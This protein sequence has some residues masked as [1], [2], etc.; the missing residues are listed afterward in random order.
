M[1]SAKKDAHGVPQDRLEMQ[2]C[3]G[4]GG[5]VLGCPKLMPSSSLGT[6]VGNSASLSSAV[7]LTVGMFAKRCGCKVS[8]LGQTGA[9][10]SRNESGACL[11]D[12]FSAC[13]SSLEEDCFFICICFIIYI[14]KFYS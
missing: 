13:H 10:R 11:L 1:G 12:S 9:E 7:H 6:G 2:G 14:C 4:Y 5:A 8:S 3:I